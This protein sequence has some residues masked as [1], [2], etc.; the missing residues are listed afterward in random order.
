MTKQD[1]FNQQGISYYVQIK[2]ADVENARFS[3]VKMTLEQLNKYLRNKH[4][5]VGEIYEVE[6][7][8]RKVEKK[9]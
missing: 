3:I 8:V 6:I 7:T 2:N 9:A 4:W 1:V 5:I